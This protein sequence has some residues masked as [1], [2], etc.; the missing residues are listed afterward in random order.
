MFYTVDLFHKLI[1]VKCSYKGL[2]SVIS[3]NML[4]PIGDL[5]H[6]SVQIEHT[7]TVFN[8]LENGNAQLDFKIITYCVSYKYK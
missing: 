7:G 6:Q 3:D 8:V 2:F 5:F 4:P 1:H